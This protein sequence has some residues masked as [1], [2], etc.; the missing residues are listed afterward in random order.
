MHRLG[1]CC[2]VRGLYRSDETVPAP[3]NRLDVSRPFRRVAKRIAQASDRGA[4]AVIEFDDRVAGPQAFANVLPGN[5]FTRRL[6]KH[7]EN[8]KGLLLESNAAACFTQFSP[9]KIQ[10]ERAK[11]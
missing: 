9:G 4:N 8:S 2:G 7:L 1:G 6:E 10:F 3:R 5:H 11:T